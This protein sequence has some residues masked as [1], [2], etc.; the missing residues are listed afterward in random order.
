MKEIIEYVRNKKNCPVG[1]ITARKAD[2]GSVYI[3][4]SKYAENKEEIDFCKANALSIARGRREKRISRDAEVIHHMNEL[5]KIDGIDE[6]AIKDR[7]MIE[8]NKPLFPFAINAV[9]DKFI[10]R[11]R[12]YFRTDDIV[13]I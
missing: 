10:E 2:N 6:I 8:E 3:G 1:C 11:C 4:W 13:V 12:R 7:V 5:A 9:I